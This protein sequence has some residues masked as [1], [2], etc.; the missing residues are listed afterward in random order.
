MFIKHFISTKVSR[1]CLE[2]IRVAVLKSRNQ[3]KD[4]KFKIFLVII[5]ETFITTLQFD[6]IAYKFRGK[7]HALHHER[8]YTELRKS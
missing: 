1:I 3:V 5:L 2:N 4:L 7:C 8:F 6:D